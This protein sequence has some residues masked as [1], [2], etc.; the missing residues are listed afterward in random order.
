[1]NT[2]PYITRGMFGEL[3][4]TNILENSV[5][6]HQPD[7]NGIPDFAQHWIGSAWKKT[8]NPDGS[9]N[10]LEAHFKFD[11]TDVNDAG[12][13]DNY[14]NAYTLLGGKKILKQQ[15]GLPELIHHPLA[16]LSETYVIYDVTV[17][18]ITEKGF[19][20]LRPRSITEKI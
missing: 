6:Y 16:R 11:Y 5:T 19:A 2:T 10:V 15:I 18:E 1:M 3:V 12:Q 9:E 20:I 4:E 8:L 7:R 14:L 13:L 17:P